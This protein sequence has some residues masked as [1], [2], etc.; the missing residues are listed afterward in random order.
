MYAVYVLACTPQ[1][2]MSSLQCNLSK[3][4]MPSLNQCGKLL[5]TMRFKHRAVVPAGKRTKHTV[6]LAAA[7]WHMHLLVI[8]NQNRA[9][10][11]S[12]LHQHN[13]SKLWLLKRPWDEMLWHPLAP[14]ED[15]NQR[16]MTGNVGWPQ[17]FKGLLVPVLIVPFPAVHFELNRMR[18]ISA[19]IIHKENLPCISCSTPL[20]N[21]GTKDGSV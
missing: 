3:P 10:C 14:C 21:A 7:L 17:R 15:T 11:S 20:H 18:A 4:D 16:K 1:L 9:G 5:S 6:T 2:T 12:Q 19:W 13:P 8:K